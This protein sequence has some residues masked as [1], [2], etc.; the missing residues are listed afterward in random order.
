MKYDL[1]GYYMT[2]KVIF[3]AFFKLFFFMLTVFVL[4]FFDKYAAKKRHIPVLMLFDVYLKSLRVIYLA[5]KLR[6]LFFFCEF[7]LFNLTEAFLRDNLLS[8]NTKMLLSLLERIHSFYRCN[9]YFIIDS[10]TY[11]LINKTKQNN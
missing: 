2:V 3:M 10:Y 7:I 4:F 5:Y 6:T 1:F 8:L 11:L 9:H